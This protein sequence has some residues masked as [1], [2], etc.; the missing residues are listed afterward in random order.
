MPAGGRGYTRVP[1]LVCIWS[2]APYLLNNS[3]GYY[4]QDPSVEGRHARLRRR[5][6]QDALARAA[7]RRIPSW[8]NWFPARS[9][10]SREQSYLTIPRG[11]QPDFLVRIF[12]PLRDELPWL[13]NI[14]GDIELGPIPAGAPVGLLANLDVRLDQADLLDRLEHDFKLAQ[15]VIRIKRDLKRH[16][17]GRERRTGRARSLPTWSIRCWRSA[18]ARTSWSIAAI[19]SAPI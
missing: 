9:T 1:S 3:V 5:D 15:L 11:F 8:A 19:I 12:T 18:N 6:R 7:G 10:A 16:S 14:N 4:V 13:F 17:R 2:Q